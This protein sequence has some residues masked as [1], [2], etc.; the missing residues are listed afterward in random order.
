MSGFST[1]AFPRSVSDAIGGDE[2]LRLLT[3]LVAIATT[4]ERFGWEP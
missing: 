2:N 3:E 4:I 1:A